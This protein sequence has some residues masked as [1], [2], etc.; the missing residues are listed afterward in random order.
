MILLENTLIFKG[1]N[2]EEIK[3][4]QR[5]LGFNQLE[6]TK[7]SIYFND[8]NNIIVGVLIEGLVHL[9]E[10]YENGKEQLFE[11]YKP[12]D[13]FI[14]N[15]CENHNYMIKAINHSR[16]LF[17]EV[18]QIYNPAKSTC[19]VKGKIM[20]NLI[21]ILE[22]HNAMLSRKIEICSQPCLRKKILLYFE[23]LKNL[24][25]NELIRVPY[26]REDL[27]DYLLCNRSALSRELSNM[28]KEKIIKMRKDCIFKL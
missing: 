24:N 21:C 16:I 19:K 17:L 7:K 10:I 6:I 12:G 2:Q 25:G 20:E 15:S 14:L 1:L 28:K 18:S 26:N 11:R 4:A 22:K 8:S 5:C 23:V 3:N 13:S 9:V 27:S